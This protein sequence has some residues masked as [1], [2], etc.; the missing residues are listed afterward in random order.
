MRLPTFNLLT[1][2]EFLDGKFASLAMTTDGLVDSAIS[3]ATDEANDLIT[4]NHPHFALIT[5]IVTEASI[6]RI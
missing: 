2:L 1:G 4:V 3:T 5:K 6:R